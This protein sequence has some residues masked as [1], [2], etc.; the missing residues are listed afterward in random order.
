MDGRSVHVWG[1]GVLIEA[2]LAARVHG[3]RGHGLVLLGGTPV[4]LVARKV[5]HLVIHQVWPGVSL[6]GT[7]DH[8]ASRVK[9]WENV[10]REIRELTL[11]G[12]RRRTK[13]GNLGKAAEHG[14]IRINEELTIVGRTLGTGQVKVRSHAHVSLDGVELGTGALVL[15]VEAPKEVG[16]GRN[17]AIPAINRRRRS[18]GEASYERTR[19]VVELAWLDQGRTRVNRAGVLLRLRIHG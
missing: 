18:L 5:L 17:I 1:H 9:V 11:V 12:D 8:G 15:E 6:H 4:P 13:G 14:G 7:R 19:V 3:R 2:R 16:D 10:G